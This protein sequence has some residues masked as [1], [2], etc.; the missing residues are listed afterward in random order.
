MVIY[1]CQIYYVSAKKLNK[2][3]NLE[4]KKNLMYFIL[5]INTTWH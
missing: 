1:D 5:L 4:K 2:P 3:P